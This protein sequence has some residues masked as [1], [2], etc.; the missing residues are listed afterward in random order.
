MAQGRGPPANG[1]HRLPCLSANEARG[2]PTRKGKRATDFQM[3][4]GGHRERGFS[5]HGSTVSDH[6]REAAEHAQTRMHV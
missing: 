4:H 6:V 1:S 3:S 5:G 2:R